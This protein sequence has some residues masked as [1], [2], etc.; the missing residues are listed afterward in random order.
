MTIETASAKL[1]NAS[2]ALIAARKVY[3]DMCTVV[4]SEQS[5]FERIVPLH[6]AVLAAESAEDWASSLLVKAIAQAE[7]RTV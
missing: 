6:D 5:G 2:N 1:A 3:S 4:A 7:G